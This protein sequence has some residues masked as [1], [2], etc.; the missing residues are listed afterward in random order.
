MD[1]FSSKKRIL[2]RKPVSSM[3]TYL[4][5]KLWG[6]AGFE[7]GA[8]QIR[9]PLRAIPGPL[10]GEGNQAIPHS[11]QAHLLRSLLAQ[12][13]RW[14]QPHATVRYKTPLI[15]QHATMGTHKGNS[16]SQITLPI[17]GPDSS[18]FDSKAIWNILP[19]QKPLL[20]LKKTSNTY[21]NAHKQSKKHKSTKQ[22]IKWKIYHN[23]N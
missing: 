21:R 17:L 14:G 9:C 6:T 3:F 11:P 22:I 19:F 1:F 18:I 10:V 16:L 4:F 23:G 5:R 15:G 12:I 13:A 20:A 8:L 7:P 2:I